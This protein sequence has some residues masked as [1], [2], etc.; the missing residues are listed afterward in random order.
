MRY[1]PAFGVK[2][3]L[4]AL[5]TRFLSA[6]NQVAFRDC[7]GQWRVL[8]GFGAFPNLFFTDEKTRK[9]PLQGDEQRRLFVPALDS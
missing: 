6:G 8:N 9:N 2:S 7:A 4:D 5:F 3:G 1:Y